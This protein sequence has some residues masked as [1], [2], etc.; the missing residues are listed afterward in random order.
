MWFSKKNLKE[1]LVD[2]LGLDPNGDVAVCKLKRDL[3]ELKLEKEIAERDI[4][5]LVTLKEEKLELDHQKKEVELEGTF[6]KKEMVLQK[7]YHDKVLAQTEKAGKEM[8][9]IH[10]QILEKLPT[11]NVEYLKEG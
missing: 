11:F 9:A 4:R 6:Q 3:E 8:T 7:E 10:E 1:V 5:H 2:L